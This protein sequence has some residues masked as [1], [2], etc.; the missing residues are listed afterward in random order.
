MYR[1]KKMFIHKK[2][3]YT[4]IC[5]ILKLKSLNRMLKYKIKMFFYYSIIWA[6]IMSSSIL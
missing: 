3:D 2:L 5:H 4:H 1:N 6:T